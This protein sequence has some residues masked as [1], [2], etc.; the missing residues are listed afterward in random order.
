MP[1]WHEQLY[2]DR[3]P[4]LDRLLYTPITIRRYGHCNFTDAEVLAAFAVLVL[5]VSGTDLVASSS[6]LP[7]PAARSEFVALAGRYGAHP[8]LVP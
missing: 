6:V 7:Q 2:R 1:I 5:R 4:P 8:V 3:P